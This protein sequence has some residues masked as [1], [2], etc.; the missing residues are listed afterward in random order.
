MTPP[1]QSSSTNPIDDDD[2]MFGLKELAKNKSA[3]AEPAPAPADDDDILGLLGKP[4]SEFER[5]PEPVAEEQSSVKD[6]SPDLDNPQAKAVAE[7]VDMGFPA[8]KSAIALATT[9]SG[10][11]VQAAVSYLLNQAHAQAKERSRDPSSN[12]Q[13]RSPDEF[14]ERPR[15]FYTRLAA[16]RRK[17][18]RICPASTGGKDRCS[19]KR[20]HPICVRN[21]KHVVQISQLA[22][23]DGSKA[24]TEGCS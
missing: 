7:L 15:W 9:E 8:D 13:R 17:A 19:R 16:W 4:V 5:R 12:R 21:R 3:S 1:A 10:L 23:E 24:G 6:D 18:Q 14:D 2:D 11:D 22:L 20:R